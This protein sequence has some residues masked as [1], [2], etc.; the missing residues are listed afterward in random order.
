[1]EAVYPVHV[2]NT[3]RWYVYMLYPCTHIWPSAGLDQLLFQF[4]SNQLNQLP[5]G[6][7][8]YAMKDY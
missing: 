7:G 6:M 3:I 4:S 8:F 5:L 2:P 1:M